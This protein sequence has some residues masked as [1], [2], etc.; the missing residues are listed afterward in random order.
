MSSPFP[1]FAVAIGLLIALPAFAADPPPVPAKGRAP[2]EVVTVHQA[3]TLPANVESV[4]LRHHGFVD[5]DQKAVTAILEA[6]ARHGGIRSLIFRL[7]NSKAVTKEHLDLLKTIKSLESLELIDQ[8]DF[9]SPEVFKQVA[10]IENLRH[11]KM[12][13]G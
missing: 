6:L 2:V 3:Q 10:A 5:R 12:S 1:R 13:F 9:K 8:R 11:L 7:P 4:V